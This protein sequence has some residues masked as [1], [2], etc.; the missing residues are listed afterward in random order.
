MLGQTDHQIDIVGQRVDVVIG[1]KELQIDFF[2]RA[3][4]AGNQRVNHRSRELGRRTQAHLA[5]RAA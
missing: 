3:Q 1:E 5:L 4:K 2:I